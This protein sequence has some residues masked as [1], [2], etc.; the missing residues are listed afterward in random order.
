[1]YSLTCPGQAFLDAIR[2]DTLWKQTLEKL[3]ELGGSAAIEVIKQVAISTA[4]YLL[5]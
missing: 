1:V 5:S 2:S 3:S 4:V